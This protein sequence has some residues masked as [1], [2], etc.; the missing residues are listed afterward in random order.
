VTR[1]HRNSPPGETVYVLMYRTNQL[2]SMGA[3]PSPGR[4]YVAAPGKN[5]EAGQIS[6]EDL[7]DAYNSAP[8]SATGANS[9]LQTWAVG[10][11]FTDP[12]LSYK[13]VIGTAKGPGM[14]A[15]L[16]ID[17]PYVTGSGGMII[18]VINIGKGEDKPIQY[19]VTGV[20]ENFGVQTVV[21][22]T[23]SAPPV[24]PPVVQPAPTSNWD[25][26]APTAPPPPTD[27][28]GGGA[29]DDEPVAPPTAKTSAAP[30]VAYYNVD[31][32]PYTDEDYS[33]WKDSTGKW[34]RG[35]KAGKVVAIE[36]PTWAAQ[37]AGSG[38]SPIVIGAVAL[39]LILL[40]RR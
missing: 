24:A 31:G 10:I 16:T 7:V 14:P 40:L 8:V 5:P 4:Y 2:G 38:I 33:F 12:E 34:W 6:R 35:D 11:A 17:H 39:G 15:S 3:I 21:P 19:G 22:T 9:V 27:D 26:T 18:T 29:I 23:A 37:V 36:T 20:P 1:S 25:V 30:Q 28:M 32:K 13:F